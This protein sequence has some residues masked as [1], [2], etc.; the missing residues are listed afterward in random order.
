MLIQSG[1]KEDKRPAAE[2]GCIIHKIVAEE[3]T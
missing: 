2:V 3:I 1:V